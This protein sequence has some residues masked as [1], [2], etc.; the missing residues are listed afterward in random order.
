MPNMHKIQQ[1]EEILE[2]KEATGKTVV[3]DW[4]VTERGD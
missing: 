2:K 3:V 4:K 1:Y